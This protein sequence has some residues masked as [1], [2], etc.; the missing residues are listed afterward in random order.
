MLA[1]MRRS[2]LG[3]FFSDAGLRPAPS[4]QIGVRHDRGRPT[5]PQD[6]AEVACLVDRLGS[7]D[8]RW[9]GTFYGL[10]PTIVGDAARQLLASGAIA[11][12]PLVDALED[13]SR[14]V[15]AHVVAHDA[16]RRRVSHRALEWSRGRT[17]G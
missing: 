8:I 6:V 5:E 7:A 16:V 13:E 2:R 14:F 1:H 4:R 17:I 15:A 9:N 3:C 11:I 10:M 12:P